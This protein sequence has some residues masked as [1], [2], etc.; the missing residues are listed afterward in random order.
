MM[1][2]Y[3][4]HIAALT[5]VCLLCVYLALWSLFGRK[6]LKGDDAAIAAMVICI[7]AVAWPVGLPL[8]LSWA[9]IYGVTRWKGKK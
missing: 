5:L 9:L 1:T 8:V 7:A 6:K 3:Y 2:Q 4:P